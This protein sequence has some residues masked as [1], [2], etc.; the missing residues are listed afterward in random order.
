MSLV[1]GACQHYIMKVYGQNVCDVFYDTKFKEAK[2]DYHTSFTKGFIQMSNKTQTTSVA[3]LLSLIGCLFSFSA[4]IIFGLTV[5]T[6]HG[7]DIF[8]LKP[9]EVNEYACYALSLF[10]M[11]IS[12][13]FHYVSKLKRLSMP[14]N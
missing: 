13:P 4:I 10:F 6:F 2:I 1:S 12:A 5:S 7:Q 11:L 9:L 8:N 14:L 3:F